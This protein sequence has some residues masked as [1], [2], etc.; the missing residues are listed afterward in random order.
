ME[1]IGRLTK[2]ASVQTLQDERQVVGFTI[3]INDS[4]TVKGGGKRKAVC[5]VNCSYWINPKVADSLRKG[6]IVA[7]YGRMWVNAYTN[8]EGHA[9][10]VANFHV[11]NIRFVGG[12]PKKSAPTPETVQENSP[13]DDIPF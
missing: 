8:M 10:G 2:D 5:F 1:I 4:Y 7:L 9:V 3:A 6:T 13:V 12:S 11:N